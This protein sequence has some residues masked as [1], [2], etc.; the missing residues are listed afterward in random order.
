MYDYTSVDD[1]FID[2]VNRHARLTSMRNY[3]HRKIY[4][5]TTIAGLQKVFINRHI[6]IGI[7]SDAVLD[8]AVYWDTYKGN[9]LTQKSYEWLLERVEL[10][11]VVSSAH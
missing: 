8:I 2:S 6:G 1:Y 9:V 10:A 3:S 7:T 4:T 11:P 5:I